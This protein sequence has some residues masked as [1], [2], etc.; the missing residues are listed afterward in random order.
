MKR[1]K[2]LHLLISNAFHLRPMANVSR[3][4]FLRK[5]QHNLSFLVD[6]FRVFPLGISFQY[7]VGAFQSTATLPT[8]V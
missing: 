7:A 5:Y 1:V 2:S 6:K 3:N 4:N 8:L